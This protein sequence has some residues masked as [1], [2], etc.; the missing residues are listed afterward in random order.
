MASPI[1]VQEAP[2]GERTDS[3][4]YHSRIEEKYT[5]SLVPLCTSCLGLLKIRIC[6]LSFMLLSDCQ[7]LH[8]WI[9]ETL[10]SLP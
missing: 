10:L 4:Y 8:I 6:G 2:C 5:C 9:T 7:F 1:E 3:H